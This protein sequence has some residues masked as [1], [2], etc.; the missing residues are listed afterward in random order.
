MTWSRILVEIK[1]EVI[2]EDEEEEEETEYETE[3]EDEGPVEA[4]VTVSPPSE[5]PEKV[6]EDSAVPNQEQ[7]T[8]ERHENEEN[9]ETSQA[10]QVKIN[11]DKNDEKV[12]R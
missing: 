6:T 7:S 9:N 12:Y 1:T 11:E 5:K 10:K 2:D 4:E 8:G 3:T